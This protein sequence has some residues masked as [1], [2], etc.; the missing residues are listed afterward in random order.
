[1]TQ[2]DNRAFDFSPHLRSAVGKTM[3]SSPIN[4]RSHDFMNSE[5]MGKQ[6]P[7]NDP[8]RKLPYFL[9][10]PGSDSASSSALSFC[11]NSLPC[12]VIPVIPAPT[13]A[14]SS[15]GF[16][17]PFRYPPSISSPA[18]TVSLLFRGYEEIWANILIYSRRAVSFFFRAIY[19]TQPMQHLVAAPAFRR[20]SGRSGRTAVPTGRRACLVRPTFVG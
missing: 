20:S 19:L 12:T 6:M 8:P 11:K 16:A 15:S 3:K 2:F 7:H 13:T 5:T 14:P 4:G 9:K 10:I 17:V 1:M 18:K